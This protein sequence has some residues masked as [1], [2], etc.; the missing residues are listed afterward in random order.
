[1]QYVYKHDV[2][3]FA[4]AAHRI[5]GVNMD[6]ANPEITAVNGIRAFRAFLKSIGMPE[7]F[8]ALGAKEEDIPTLVA[9]HPVSTEG[10]TGGFV[11]LTPE[12]VANIY[13]ASMKANHI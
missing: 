2:M 13:K 11:S 8:E 10:R 12:D 1:M 6:F 4:Q 9:K 5:W 7:S 3:R